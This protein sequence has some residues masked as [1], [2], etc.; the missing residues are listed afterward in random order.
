MTFSFWR[1]TQTK[2]ALRED[3]RFASAQPRYARSKRRVHAELTPATEDP[4]VSARHT[5]ERLEEH[6]R[7]RRREEEDVGEDFCQVALPAH[8][9]RRKAPRDEE[10]QNQGREQHVTIP[11]ETTARRRQR[12]SAPEKQH[13]RCTKTT[14]ENLDRHPYQSRPP[15]SPESVLNVLSGDRGGQVGLCTMAR[16]RELVRAELGPGGK[17]MEKLKNRVKKKRA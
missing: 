16:Q 7:R 4:Q 1:E 14:R 12:R 5:P 6:A 15:P 9:R 8:A 3:D 10:L 11:R 13:Q 17:R 2:I